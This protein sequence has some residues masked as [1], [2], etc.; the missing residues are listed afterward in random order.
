MISLTKNINSKLKT[1]KLN[2][3]DVVCS[4]DIARSTGERHFNLL[5]SIKCYIRKA[6][7]NG[8]SDL[9]R[10][11]APSTFNHRGV[12]CDSYY[13]TYEG[14]KF[15]SESMGEGK[16]QEKFTNAFERAFGKTTIHNTNVDD[17]DEDNEDEESESPYSWIDAL[18]KCENTN[19]DTDNIDNSNDNDNEVHD[20]PIETGSAIFVRESI[21]DE[22]NI[23]YDKS[24]LDSIGKMSIE[25][26]N[27]GVCV[28]DKNGKRY[29]SADI[30]LKTIRLI[31]NDGIYTDKGIVKKFII[32]F[33]KEASKSV[34]KS[35]IQELMW[36][37]NTV[38]FVDRDEYN[39][40]PELYESDGILWNYYSEV[41]PEDTERERIYASHIFA[42][43]PN[44][45]EILDG[46]K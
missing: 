22:L 2:G 17:D 43:K 36:H 16:K 38:E 29:F 44:P 27:M 28:K 14:C 4:R 19:T 20:K 7:E 35:E 46:L 25:D 9:K 42:T 1:T 6:D 21:L 24:F 18:L 34:A 23:P 13:I 3:V 11:F 45:R 41:F 15:V 31:A 5:N 10:H 12:V 8:V 32:P 40:D 39:A 33:I 30:L 26:K 37:T